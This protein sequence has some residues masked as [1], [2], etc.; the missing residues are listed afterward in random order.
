MTC[1]LNCFLF[2][3]RIFQVCLGLGLLS[4]SAFAQQNQPGKATLQNTTPPVVQQAPTL[5]PELS[6]IL[7]NWE[8]AG[9]FTQ[10]LEGKHLRYI[11]DH[12]FFVEKWSS[13]EFYYEAPDKGRI[14]LDAPKEFKPGQKR[15]RGDKTYSIEAD[16]PERW[17]CDGS[18]VYAIDEDRKEFQRIPIPVESRGNNIVDG[19][20]PFLFGITKEKVIMR[21]HVSLNTPD[22]GGKHDLSQ[23]IIHLKVKPLWQQDAA[24]WQEAEVMLDARSYLPTAIR[25][26]HPGATAETV[27]V[28][29]DVERN[30]KQGIVGVVWGGSPFQPNLRGYKE[31]TQTAAEPSTDIRK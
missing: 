29:Q 17:I 13:G 24:N 28:F 10:K 9:D 15:T 12:V 20:M 25:L 1:G 19:P 3:S 5:T 11:Y 16:K 23:G 14:D 8:K 21:Y 26:I 2:R 7:D 27:Y 30:S 18:Q 6:Q 4:G 31:L 22:Q